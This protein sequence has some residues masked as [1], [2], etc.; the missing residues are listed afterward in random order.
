MLAYEEGG[1]VE[2]TFFQKIMVVVCILLAFF[3]YF[4]TIN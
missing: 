4:C 3:L 2:N 1:K